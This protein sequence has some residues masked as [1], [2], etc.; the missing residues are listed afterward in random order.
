MTITK[1]NVFRFEPDEIFL[2]R[3]ELEGV[4]VDT[5]LSLEKGVVKVAEVEKIL[6]LEPGTLRNLAQKYM[7]QNKSPYKELGIGNSSICHWVVRLSVFNKM[8]HSRIQPQI[9]KSKPSVKTIPDSISPQDLCKLEGIY[10]LSDLKGR[11]PFSHSTIKNQARKFGDESRHAMGC[12]KE[13]SQFYVDMQPFLA[14]LANF[15]YH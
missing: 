2:E 10:K 1:K 8:W 13:G 15:E 6:D 4:G 14:W 12:W 9:A 3:E 11:F 7:K 5:F